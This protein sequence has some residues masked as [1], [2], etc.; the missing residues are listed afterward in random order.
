MSNRFRELRNAV[1][2]G[3][4]PPVEVIDLIDTENGKLHDDFVDNI[5]LDFGREVDFESLMKV[6][7]TH[8]SNIHDVMKKG[9]RVREIAICVAIAYVKKKKGNI[10]IFLDDDKVPGELY[11]PTVDDKHIINNID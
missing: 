3:S 5:R 4:K 1:H 10:V 2:S 6:I 8:E 9:A 11:K 7:L